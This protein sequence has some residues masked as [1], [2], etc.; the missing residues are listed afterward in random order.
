M[1]IEVWLQWARGPMFCA[2][3]T[4]MILGLIRHV[5]IAVWEI[6]RAIRR[7]G[8]KAIAVRPL[9][10][11]T[12][13]WLFPVSRLGNRTLFGLTTLTF[14]VCVI[15]VPLF[16]AGH[17]AL[18]QRGL[19]ISW[20]ALP[21][22]LATIL[23][24]VALAMA[25]ALVLERLVARDSRMLSRFQDYALP[26]L[27]AVPFATGFLVMHPTW[28]PFAYNATLLAHVLSAN[29]LLLLIPVTK[30]SHMVLLPLT[31]LTSEVSW[32][33]PPNAGSRVAVA[34]KKEGEPV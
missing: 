22:T 25:L 6:I 3:L 12:A 23:T 29:V 2:A 9:V 27:I 20:P 15:L 7:A 1:S 11:T 34:L 24:L 21:N 10:S 26:L 18:W 33:F 30:L 5:C 13:R 17:V 31:Q 16:L 14:H 8:D 19:G 28:N 32:R 4:F